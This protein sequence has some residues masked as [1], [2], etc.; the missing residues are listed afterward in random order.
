MSRVQVPRKSIKSRA[1]TTALIATLSLTGI[2]APLAVSPAAEATTTRGKC[3][4]T[5]MKPKFAGFNNAG[6]KLVDYPIKVACEGLRDIRVQQRVWEDDDPPDPDD[7]L[8][9]KTHTHSFFF[10]GT[11]T[12][13]LKLPL[14]DTDPGSEKVYQDVRFRVT[15]GGV[16][17]GYT[18]RETSPILKIA[19]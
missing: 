13:H 4:V 15:T 8:A 14:K 6:V 16:S 7:F 3:S 1:R 17:S 10:P 18:P 12:L 19:N 11:I 9:E 5:P 2:I